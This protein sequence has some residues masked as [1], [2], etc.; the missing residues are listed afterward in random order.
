MLWVAAVVIDFLA[1]ASGFVVPGLGRS[2][3]ADWNIAGE[4]LAERCQLF[5]IIVLGESIPDTGT[6]LGHVSFT[7]PTIAA[8]VLAFLGTVA[9]WW[10]EGQRQGDRVLTGPR[11]VRVH[12]LPPV[13]GRGSRPLSSAVPR[14]SC[15][16]TCSSN[17]PCSGRCPGRG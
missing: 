1:P 16:D 15:S 12:V 10:V 13:D 17:R 4:H 3:T 5:M 11:P 2:T 9:L 8:F 7:T 6:S 14:C